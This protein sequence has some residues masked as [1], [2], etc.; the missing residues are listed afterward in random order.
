MKPLKLSFLRLD[1]DALAQLGKD[2]EIEDDG[3]GQEGVFAR[4]VEDDG[5]V[6][7]HE[8]LGRVLIHCPLAVSHIRDVLDHN[9]EE[10]KLTKTNRLF[11]T[12]INQRS[13]IVS[14]F[15]ETQSLSERE[16][17]SHSQCG[18]VSP[19]ARTRCC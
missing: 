6:A 5:V 9:L 1:Q 12:T 11:T 7:S 19:W 17:A 14:A 18:Q 13:L 3:C 8:D 4:V 2:D 15:M 16:R 10:K